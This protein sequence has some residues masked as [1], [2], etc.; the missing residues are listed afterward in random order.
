MAAAA[1]VLVAS[2]QG[3]LPLFIGG[4]MA[5]FVFAGIGNGSTYTM[6]P[7]IFT[8]RVRIAAQAGA[9]EAVAATEARRLSGA[10]IGIA[11]AVDE[12][13]GQHRDLVTTRRELPT[14]GP[15]QE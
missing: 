3:S 13:K 9:G 5:L 14:Q 12:L 7:A 10:L 8:S 11:G 4:F 15:A 2:F 6:I 1:V